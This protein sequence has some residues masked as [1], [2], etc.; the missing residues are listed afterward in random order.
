MEGLNDGLEFTGS[1]WRAG[2]SCRVNIFP[3]RR[4][5]PCSLAQAQRKTFTNT[6][7]L[8]ARTT[9]STY[10]PKHP[11]TTH[12]SKRTSHKIKTTRQFLQCTNHHGHGGTPTQHNHIPLRAA[13]DLSE[14]PTIRRVTTEPQRPQCACPSMPAI[15]CQVTS[16]S[17]MTQSAT[18]TRITN[19]KRRRLASDG[20]HWPSD[21]VHTCSLSTCKDLSLRRCGPSTAFARFESLDH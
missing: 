8:C 14:A 12:P 10:I 5:V 16:L 3:P 19:N 17:N 21:Y 1:L 2:L 13:R 7:Q 18:T 11:F 20:P 9:S 15:Q 6:Y 4:L